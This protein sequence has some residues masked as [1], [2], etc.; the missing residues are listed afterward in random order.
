MQLR[1]EY[2]DGRVETMGTNSRWTTSAGPITFDSIYG[3]ETYDAR[4][5]KPGWDTPDYDDSEWSMARVV[6]APGGKLV[7]QTM[8]PIKADRTIKP[9]KLTEPKP[10]VFVFDMG[11]NFA[12]YAE[13]N[14][15]APAGTKVV[16]KYG[17]RLHKDGMIDRAD[18]Q[19]HIV[20]VDPSQQYQTDTYIFDGSPS[21]THHVSRFTYHGFQYIEV[22]GFPGKPTLDSLRGVFIHSAIRS[23]ERR[24]AK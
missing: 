2:S 1:V 24:A 16:M 5:E 11:Q 19:Q 21:S 23:E 3:G 8:Q 4:A 10:G 18:I 14:L 20:R 15:S 22:T 17:E 12:G 13:L 7:A 9:V 6:S